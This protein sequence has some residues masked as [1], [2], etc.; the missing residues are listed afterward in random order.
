M[1]DASPLAA[2]RSARVVPTLPLALGFPLPSLPPL[3][4]DD[5]LPALTTA[6]ATSR[7]AV[8]VAPPGAGKTTRV[9]L[10]LLDAAWRGDGRVVMLEPRRLAARAAAQQMAR[11]LG[12]P[13]GERVGYRVRRASRVSARTV[14]EV[15]TEGVF[16]RQWLAD[17]SL[18]GVT[19][20]ILDE[21]HERHVQTDL[22]FALTLLT[23]ELQ[24]PDLAV[25]VMSATLDAGPIAAF[26]DDAPVIRSE[27]RSFPVTTDWRAPR[28]GARIDAHVASVIAD[29]V[30]THAGD[31]LTFLPGIAEIDRVARALD[32][33]LP[34]GAR[35]HRLH[36][37]LTLEA[38]DDAI[39]ASAPGERK[40]VLATA[41]AESSLTIEGVRVVVDAGLARVP[42]YDVRSGM[43]RLT[44][45]RVSRASAD[46]RRGRA[47][48]VAPGVCVRCWSEGDEAQLRDRAAPERLAVDLTSLALDL[49]RAGLD[50]ARDLR[51]LDAPPATALARAQELL[52]ELECLDASSQLTA[53]GAAVAALGLEPRLAHL[54]V[55]GVAL[56][57]GALACDIAALLSERDIFTTDASRDDPDLAARVIALGAPKPPPTVDRG[58]WHRVRDESA[59]LRR[60]LRVADA[61]RDHS[62]VGALLALAYPDR[63][64]QRRRGDPQRYRLRNGRGA[65]FSTPHPLGASP[66][67]AIATLD[68]DALESRVWLAASLSEAELRDAFGTAITTH[69]IAEW[70]AATD[71]ARVVVE[72]RLGALVLAAAPVRDPS[73]ATLRT[74]LL[75]E[76]RRRGIAA[77]PWSPRALALRARLGFLR[78]HIGDAWPA[79]DDA[80]LADR[81]DGW[82]APRLDG[83]RSWSALAAIDLGDALL[84]ALDWEQRRDLDALAP[85]HITVPT[86]SRI[87]VDYEDVQQ[88]AIAVRLQELFGLTDGPRLL[89]GRV[90]VVLRLLSP[91]HRPVQVTS[92]LAGFWASSYAE[93]RKEMRGRY[94]RHPWPEDPRAAEPTR[95]AKP[96]GT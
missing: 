90:P 72:E 94:P 89:G 43:T 31:V 57:H 56:G 71:R 47:G 75:D 86:G 6:L 20:V 42:R 18:D 65:H 4:V 26:L 5:A 38:Q 88:P 21:F 15:V 96:R 28:D 23:R 62:A 58:R 37:S 67:L 25:L 55:R 17:P 70:D 91:A 41:I 24:R 30:R 22:G 73:A 1:T 19:C 16:T 50:P 33:S 46:Q 36:G 95:R 54:L 48:R 40:V 2:P 8:L 76:V 85:T 27:G 63:V 29:A 11:L 10:A 60:D 9:P 35:I 77:L 14:I 59:A 3:P 87:A 53:H 7:R 68:G 52:R 13:V 32:G 80:T 81:V 34:S 78:A 93:V 79:V 45:V 82:L 61:P 44:T 84:D 69:E 12:E 49:A 39:R 74:V 64:A 51:W 83:V 92:D 66:W